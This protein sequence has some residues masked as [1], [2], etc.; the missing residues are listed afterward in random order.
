MVM[1]TRTKTSHN[2]RRNA[3]KRR[4]CNN[5]TTEALRSISD[6]AMNGKSSQE[7]CYVSW[8]QM[9]PHSAGSRLAISGTNSEQ[10]KSQR[11]IRKHVHRPRR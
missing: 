6:K 3:T 11:A 10:A 7:T 4:S 1:T 8:Q 5:E 2:Y 9:V